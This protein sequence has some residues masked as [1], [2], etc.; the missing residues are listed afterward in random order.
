VYIFY[1]KFSLFSRKEILG[2]IL[3]VSFLPVFSQQYN[4]RT[5]SVEEGL[6]QSKIH[7]LFESSKGYLWVGTF[8]SGVVSFDGN[9]FIKYTIKDG[10]PGN[11]IFSIAEDKTGDI[12]FGTDA[13]LATYN[14]RKIIG[15]PENSMLY[16]KKIYKILAGKNYLWIATEHG[17]VQYDYNKYSLITTEDGLLNNQVNNIYEDRAGKLWASCKG[18][19]VVVIDGNKKTFY[20]KDDGLIDNNIT[21][22]YHDETG[23]IWIGTE[24]GISVLKENKFIN[25]TVADGLAD[26]HITKI[27]ADK[28]GDLWIGTRGAGLSYYNRINFK[29]INDKNGLSSNH[30]NDIIQ[31]K[32]GSLWFATAG[33]GICRYQGQYFISYTTSDGLSSNSVTAISEDIYGNM[34]FGT[35]GKGVNKF[36]DSRFV[37]LQNEKNENIA[38]YINVITE[39]NEGN[40]WIGTSGKGVYIYDGKT[41]KHISEEKGLPSSDI[42]AIYVDDSSN[43]W[44]GGEGGLCKY[45]NNQIITIGRA[46]GLNDITISSIIE[47]ESHNFW[48]GTNK[49]LYKYFDG[50]IQ[51]F[52]KNNGLPSN[53]IITLVKNSD[54]NIFAGTDA[55]LCLISGNN[56]FNYGLK[57]GLSSDNIYSLIFDETGAIYLGTDKGVDK[58][59]ISWDN[60]ISTTR[61]YRKSD[62]F[63]GIECNPGAIYKDKNGDFWFGTV[64]GAVKFSPQMETHSTLSPRVYF[65]GLKLFYGDTDWKEY[66][67]TTEAWSNMPVNL[68]LPYNKNH[69]T[70]YFT[71]IH[72]GKPEKV[73]YRYMLKDVDNDWSPV[74]SKNNITYSNLP[75]GKFTFVI[76]A[77]TENDDWNNAG[78][79]EFSFEIKPPIWKRVWFIIL[80]IAAI[81]A[82]IYFSVMLRIRALEKAKKNLEEKVRLRTLE[83]L[84]Q[85]EE[86]E[87]LSIVASETVQG[88]I[89]SDAQGNI[90]WLN[91]GLRRMT[92]YEENQIREFYKNGNKDISTHPPIENII[93]EVKTKNNSF[94]F[95][96]MHVT[97]AGKTKWATA[98]AN[99][100]FSENGELKKIFFIY[101]DI[102][103]RRNA[104]EEIRKKNRDITE[105]IYYAKQIQEAI[106]PERDILY[107]SVPDSFV[108]YMPKDI[109][110]GDF[111]WFSK[112]DNFLV[113]AVADCTGHG[114]PGALMSM[115]GNEF[116][117]Q[118]INKEEEYDPAKILS[119]MDYRIVRSLHQSVGKESKDGM[120]ISICVINL[121]TL[122]MKYSGAYRPVY[123][124]RQ[125]EIHELKPHPYS[126]GGVYRVPKE[127]QTQY[128]QLKKD[129][130]LYLMTDGYVDQFG[131]PKTKKFLLKRMLDLLIDIKDYE[132][133]DQKSALRKAHLNWKKD[134]FQVDDILIVAAKF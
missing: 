13:G 44:I 75:D 26:N 57:D 76:Q 105:S 38:D 72:L 109:V 60:A 23:A 24:Q 97:K 92:G 102:T 96:S 130:I 69:L 117:H 29:T 28:N 108:L 35:S 32:S 79:A 27:F 123:I 34:W 120:D 87:N 93:R 22:F 124:I 67:D 116:L 56:F 21:C 51:R 62:G 53:N 16:N 42:F 55:G 74:T 59:T 127:F 43:V 132:L 131:G 58:V 83:I 107:K 31:D 122:E 111:Y 98:V 89:I 86:L 20:T 70:F 90:E 78:K 85:K 103:E 5:F 81:S 100:V 37:V 9:N 8:A 99:P 82:A 4:F 66:S 71:G 112:T 91:D 46:A 40:I 118:V 88:V 12:L 11:E 25:Y 48:I 10:L 7:T 128:F 3:L 110:S 133:S 101:T 2:I 49:G 63:T 41:L 106:L 14:G 30:I 84:K 18:Y 39:D 80:F 68:V 52:T 121:D 115:I 17:L 129:D 36:T 119:E 94:Q 73:T 61:S 65:T 45:K 113:I 104:E 15:Y 33:G 126:I 6:P 125:E 19:G 50:K 54:N 47:G 64:N 95:E 114:V 77:I 1:N 134:N